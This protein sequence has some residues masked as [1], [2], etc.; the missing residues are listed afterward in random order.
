MQSV[1]GRKFYLSTLFK[2]V[3]G[4]RFILIRKR[5]LGSVSWKNGSGSD[6]RE[7]TIFFSIKNIFIQKVMFCDDFLLPGSGRPK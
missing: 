5:I 3:F 6:N 7:N 1:E 2:S 4:I